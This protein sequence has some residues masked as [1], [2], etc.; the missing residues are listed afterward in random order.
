MTI[1]SR[2]KSLTSRRRLLQQAGL[3]AGALAPLQA[4]ADTFVDLDLAGAPTRREV[5]EAFPQKGAMVLQRSRP[6]LLETP[7]QVFDRDVITPNDQF[8]VR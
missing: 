1:R 2:E 7:W 3:F 8:F 4:W 5:T 6:P